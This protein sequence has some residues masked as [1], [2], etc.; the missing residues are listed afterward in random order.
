MEIIIFFGIAI[1][2]GVMAVKGFKDMPKKFENIRRGEINSIISNN[3]SCSDED[4]EN[5]LKVKSFNADKIVKYGDFAA[6]VIDN[7]QKEFALARY[8]VNSE[9]LIQSLLNVQRNELDYYRANGRAFSEYAKQY[10]NFNL[11][12][13]F[14]YSDIIKYEVVDK[15]EVNKERTFVKE[16]NALD[17]VSGAIAG[18]MMQDTMLFG[19]VENAALVGAMAG[20]A[21]KQVTHEKVKITKNI[22]FD[23][24]LTLN[25][26]QNP[27]IV[28]T[29]D[30]ENELR[31]IVSVLEYMINNK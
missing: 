20:N 7:T 15:T 29:V 24:V 22:L 27:N 12:Q 14:K 2:A 4:W 16:S 25:N 13:R 18:N 31:D 28:F 1:F 17:V 23:I 3:L 5:S 10:I 19:H 9:S 8:T 26:I 6:F 11:S 21:G 30:N